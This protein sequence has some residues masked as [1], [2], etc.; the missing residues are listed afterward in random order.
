MRRAFF[1]ALSLYAAFLFFVASPLDAATDTATFQVTITIQAECQITSANNLAFGTQGVLSANVDASTT[2][3]VQCTNTTPYEIALN[4][5]AGAG[6]TIAVRKMTGPGAATI[7]YTLYEDAGRTDLWGE[8][9]L[10]DTVAGV[11][12]GNAQS[13]T[14]YGRVP[15][16]ATPAIGAY[17]DTITITVTF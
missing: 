14:V 16:Q 1:Y 10:T 12:N 6:A 7:N 11:G 8:T 5:G 9:A 17:T 15:P 3:S 2:L 13:F 4:A